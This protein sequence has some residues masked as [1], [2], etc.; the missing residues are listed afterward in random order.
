MKNPNKKML[1]LIQN[2]TFFIVK[3][4]QLARRYIIRINLRS[5]TTNLEG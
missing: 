3:I 2:N 5:H 1:V 4:A